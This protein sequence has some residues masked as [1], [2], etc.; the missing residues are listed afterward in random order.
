MQ[1]ER[2]CTHASPIPYRD[3]ENPASRSANVSALT[4]N[5]RLHVALTRAKHLVVLKPQTERCTDA[6]FTS[7]SRD[8]P[9]HSRD[10][11]QTRTDAKPQTERRTHAKPQAG[12][13]AKL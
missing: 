10:P 5:R 7:H 3:F 1:A 2:E 8:V 4:P 12:R 11:P 6:T 9:S 13:R